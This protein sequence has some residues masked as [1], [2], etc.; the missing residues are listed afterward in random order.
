MRSPRGEDVV[1]VPGLAHRVLD[2]GAGAAGDEV[3]GVAR[4]LDVLQRARLARRP[5]G[6]AGQHRVDGGGDELDVAELLGRDAR[7]QVV[8]RPRALPVAEVERLVGV[9]H[10][11]R[12]LAELAAQQ[13]LNGGGPHRIGIRRRRELGLQS[14]DAENH[15]SPP[16]LKIGSDGVAARVARANMGAIRVLGSDGRGR[17]RG[18]G[19]WW[20]ASNVGFPPSAGGRTDVRRL[21]AHSPLV[22]GHSPSWPAPV[23]VEPRAPRPPLTPSPGDAVLGAAYAGLC[24]FTSYPSTTA[25]R[26][27]CR[28]R[29][30]APADSGR[31]RRRRAAPRARARRRRRDQVGSSAPRASAR[32]SRVRAP[33]SGTMSSPRLSTQAIATWATVMP[34]ASAAARSASTRARL[35][36]RFSLEARR[37]PRKSSAAAR[38]PARSAR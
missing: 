22:A 10:E 32:R 28:A 21:A 2:E 27:R 4:A 37:G 36:S 30:S 19:P 3:L 14:I 31:R 1:A 11:G 6:R 25:R 35:R 17:S 16:K 33:T 38:G 20:C 34:L 24:T 8:E 18:R 15:A 9:V 26:A 7:E 12:H 23:R 5:V 29:P 13:L